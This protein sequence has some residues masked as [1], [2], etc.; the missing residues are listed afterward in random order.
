MNH[1]IRGSDNSSGCSIDQASGSW[2]ENQHFIFENPVVSVS[3]Q[4]YEGQILTA[5]GS[6]LGCRHESVGL[7]IL[8]IFDLVTHYFLTREMHEF[9]AR[10]MVSNNHRSSHRSSNPSQKEYGHVPG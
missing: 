3:K 8:H 2:L 9:K 4:S 7:K 10:G 1:G 6:D 5:E